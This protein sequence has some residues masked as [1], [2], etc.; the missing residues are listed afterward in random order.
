MKKWIQVLVDEHAY[1]SLVGLDGGP[2]R[3]KLTLEE[4][5]AFGKPGRGFVVHEVDLENPVEGTEK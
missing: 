3:Y 4:D 1:Q 5:R 2:W